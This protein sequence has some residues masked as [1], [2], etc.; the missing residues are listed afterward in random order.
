MSGCDL[1]ILIVHTFEASL[2]R[3]T[4]RGLRRAAPRLR[5]EVCVIDNNPA[6]G[7]AELLA[8]EFPDVR[9]LAQDSNRGFGAAMNRGFVSARGRYV[10]VFNP[11]IIVKP[12]ALEELHGFMEAHQDVGIVGPR[13][14]N[15]DGSLQYSCYRFHEPLVP[16]YRRTPLGRLPFAQASIA[17]FL[18]A[19]VDHDVTMDVDWLMGSAL[20]IRRSAL[21]EVGVFDDERFFMYLE[22]TDLCRRFWEKRW[23]VVYHPK[24]AMVHYHRRASDDGTLMTQLFSRLTREHIKSALRYFRKYAGKQNPRV[25]PDV[26]HSTGP[27]SG[28]A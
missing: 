4:L 16:V 22:D 11:D 14:E 2:I 3:Q 27:E 7:I 24:V 19:D 28:R 1:S 15:P 20:F 26:Q 5:Y 13:L 21:T 8:A 10:L 12:G 6:A 23:R 17:R 25:S 9:Y 18:M